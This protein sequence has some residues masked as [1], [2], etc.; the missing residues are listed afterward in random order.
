MTATIALDVR[1]H[2]RN[3]TRA[4][5]QASDAHKTAGREWYAA[6]HDLAR[7]LD[8]ESPAR[9]A[10]VIAV[11][12]PRVNWDINAR[13]ARQAYA[14]RAGTIGKIHPLAHPRV[15][16]KSL[17]TIHGHGEK[18]HKILNG[19]HPANV[20]SG[21]KVTAFWQ[22]IA[23]P[24]AETVC[25]DRHAVDIA[26]GN[27]SDERTRGLYLGRVGNYERI[28]GMYVRAARILS[29]EYGRH[30]T[31]AEVQATTWLSWRANK[32]EIAA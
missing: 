8:P 1:P 28:A 16:A 5:R 3:I 17:P 21:P 11:L 13:L 7:E 18:A 4:Y 31:P 10:A 9:A 22:L 24:S 26:F 6:A 25:V 19:I 2:T 12:S 23:N 32:R 27:V 20:V 14:Q 30:I 29:R 15:L